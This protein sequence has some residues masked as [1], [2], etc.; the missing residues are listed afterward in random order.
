MTKGL[1]K[2]FPYRGGY[3]AQVTC[4]NGKRPVADFE[5]E[6]EAVDWIIETLANAN[7]EHEP[8][9][10]GPTV[11][12][13]AQALNHYASLYTINKGSIQ[14]ELN[15]I[16]QYLAGAGLELLRKAE[17]D[18]GQTVL[19]TYRPEPQPQGWQDHNDARRALRSGTIAARTIL[20]RKRCSVINTADIRRLMTTMKT[21]GLSASTIQKE[22]ALL[23]HMFNMGAKEW[24]WKG[25]EN[26]TAGIKLGS[27]KSR[28]VVITKEQEAALWAAVAKCDNPYF[29]PLV[30]CAMETTLRRGSLLGM[31]WEKTDLEGRIAQVPSKTGLVNA[32]LSLHIVKVLTDMPRHPSG[33]VFPMSGNAVEMA[34]DGVRVKAKLP[35]LQFKDI[36][37]LGATAYAR[38]GLNAHQL[39][40]I[41]GHK[42]LFMAQVYV[43][44]VASDVLNVMDATA[45]AVPVIQVP[46]P[47]TG[48]AAN[49]LKEKRSSR[50]ADAVIKRLQAKADPAD[51]VPAVPAAPAGTNSTSVARADE[52]LVTA[53]PVE[54]A[55]ALFVKAATFDAHTSVPLAAYTE[56][57]ATEASPTSPAPFVDAAEAAEAADVAGP[58]RVAGNVLMFRPRQRVA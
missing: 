54:D 50:M 36:R 15:R 26:P 35:E 57:A 34:W 29:W 58:A 7:T 37:H 2:P 21:E 4:K 11:T 43:N 25:F 52:V 13:L 6:A 14:S 53:P 3:R 18:K 5:F 28:F 39:K 8:E 41:L 42:T 49:M 22:V 1:P 10:S 9:L 55:T 48:S 31:R 45:P 19:E 27:S 44:L 38:R 46:P 20:A 33:K 12:T 32:P 40:A 24:Q 56:Q 47:A 51:G 23:R 30:V 17:N 16:N